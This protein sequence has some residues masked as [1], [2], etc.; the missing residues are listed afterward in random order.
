[1]GLPRISRA[2]CLLPHHADG[3]KEFM[4][5]ARLIRLGDLMTALYK[6]CHVC[7]L[8]SKNQTKKIVFLLRAHRHTKMHSK[9]IETLWCCLERAK[10]KIIFC[11]YMHLCWSRNIGQRLWRV[12]LHTCI[13][14]SCRPRRRSSAH[15]LRLAT[16]CAIE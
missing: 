8:E 2:L 10:E 9:G 7:R 15:F 1:M 14:R 6:G 4:N 16:K 3:Q 12:I 11:T 5:A 13:R